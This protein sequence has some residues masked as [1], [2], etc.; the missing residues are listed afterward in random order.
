MFFVCRPGR[1]EETQLLL[2]LL[3]VNFSFYI[4]FA[5]VCCLF[6]L[7]ALIFLPHA[8]LSIVCSSVLQSF[9]QQAFALALKVCHRTW[10]G[11]GRQEL[12]V[13]CIPHYSEYCVL[14][15]PRILPALTFYKHKI[16]TA[17]RIENIWPGIHREFPICHFFVGESG[18]QAFFCYFTALPATPLH[19]RALFARTQKPF[20]TLVLSAGLALYQEKSLKVSIQHQYLPRWR[21][22]RPGDELVQLMPNYL[23]RRCRCF[24]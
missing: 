5:A 13:C 11:R 8:L 12:L 19:A 7:C 15:H 18:W 17:S 2:L 6:S 14:R 21:G 4:F 16:Q 10:F 9:A 1:L 24:Y 20:Y 3:V 22:R 23:K